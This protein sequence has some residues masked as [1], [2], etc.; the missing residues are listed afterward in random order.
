MNMTWNLDR[1]YPSFESSELR[2]DRGLLSQHIQALKQ[3]AKSNLKAI[4]VT[5]APV[6]D[7]LRIY[8][9]YKSVYVCLLAYAE[10]TLSADSSHA[11]AMNLAD[12]I[13]HMNSE[14]AGIVAAFNGWVSTC[15]HIEELIDSSPYLLEHQ[16]YLKELLRQSRYALSEELEVAISKMQ[17]TGS[18]AWSRLYMERTS[19]TLA[20]I[21]VEGE[22]RQVTLAELRSMAY[23]NNAVLRKAAYEAEAEACGRIAD[24]SAACLNGISGEALTIYEMRGYQSSLEKV[25]VASRMDND[26]LSA[27]L[28]A[29]KESLPTFHAYYQKKAKL[30]G[31]PGKLPFYDIFAPVGEENGKI[32]YSDA[33]DTIVASFANFS[34]EL[35]VFAQ[36]AFDQQWIDA[37]PRAG[38]GGYGLCIDIFPLGESRIMTQFTGN[39]MDVSI[40]AHELGHAYHSSCLMNETML[41]TDYPI[42]IAETASIFC[43][44]IV[45]QALLTNSTE[46][47]AQLILERSISDAGYYLVDFYARYLFELRLYERR[48]AG[49][50]SVQELNDLMRTC[51][52]EAYG[53]SIDPDT[54]HPYMWMNKIGYFIA[55]NEFL[56]FPYSF[57]LLF[58]KGLYAEYLKRGE[59]FVAKYRKFLS[60]TSKQNIVDVAKT[61]DVD[62]QSIDFWRSAL[63]LI[64]KDI[65]AFS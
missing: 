17:S 54:I 39:T 2:G 53:E 12:D 49:P 48:A 56:N 31:H 1:L 41:N 27:M 3:W 29:L 11:E 47:E 19:S 63:K 30:L 40:L 45:N 60:V 6:E 36:K 55:G 33:Q 9:D 64:E 51:M 18:K 52:L 15:Q 38:K 61:M 14:I 32:S 21:M 57:G 42:P 23:E 59:G 58:S 10:L 50:L 20:D 28:A 44:T 22:T 26:T 37:E 24:I 65:A 62:V 16:F 4:G 25:L 46:K 35:S 34:E 8:N 13:E 7:F 5:A 43:E